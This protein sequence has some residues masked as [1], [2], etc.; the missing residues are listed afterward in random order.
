[1]DLCP[2]SN[3]CQGACHKFTPSPPH[4]YPPPLQIYNASH[5]VPYDVPHV[6][7][8]MILR[9]MHVNFSA[10]ADG[11]ARIPSSVGADAKPHFFTLGEA[12]GGEWEGKPGKSEEQHTAME[13]GE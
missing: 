13:E 5:M 4:P 8:D 6:A 11:T 7:H 10:L 12:E 3:V 9:F 1:M 2:Q